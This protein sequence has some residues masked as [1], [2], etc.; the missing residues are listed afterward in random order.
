MKTG[1]IKRAIDQALHDA[2]ASDFAGYDP[3]DALNTSWTFLRKGKWPPVLL[4]QV[5]KRVPIN[6][7]PLLGIKKEHNPKGIG[8]LLEAS[9]LMERQHPGKYSATIDRLLT[10]LEEL[11]S[12]GYTGACW[13]YN[14]EWAS[15]VKVL[16]A[17]SPTVV[18][19][20]F[21]SKA[22]FEVIQ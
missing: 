8:L 20:G 1:D 17:Y 22:L 15:P 2:A 10:L 5:M 14:F 3:Y 4:I 18:V 6:L 21:I 11:Q 16:P 9:A 19:T 12:E 7:R 13:G